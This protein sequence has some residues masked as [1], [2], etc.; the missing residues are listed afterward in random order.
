MG[1]K[2]VCPHRRCITRV[3]R[4]PHQSRTGI[5]VFSDEHPP[6]LNKDVDER[7]LRHSPSRRSSDAR[8]RKRIRLK[9]VQETGELS[10][11]IVQLCMRT[12]DGV[13]ISRVSLARRQSPRFSRAFVQHL[14]PGFLQ[15][16]PSN[17][18]KFTAVPLLSHK[19][20]FL[21]STEALRS[22]INKHGRHK[23]QSW[24][25]KNPDDRGECGDAP[26]CRAVA[27]R[28]LVVVTVII[29]VAV[30]QLPLQANVTMRAKGKRAR[31]CEG[32]TRAVRKV[33]DRG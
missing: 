14:R 27:A 13:N 24:H 33:G 12:F 32:R 11:A 23:R 29:G 10:N 4:S 26:H 30:R 31:E 18:A 22:S 9:I 8:K 20:I 16:W 7:E 17:I 15:R 1:T 3:T 5:E 6:S 19:I 28:V 2:N 21:V 25:L